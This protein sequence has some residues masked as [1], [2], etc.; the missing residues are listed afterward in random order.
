MQKNNTE[1]LKL[2]FEA[3][4]SE[5]NTLRQNIIHHS[6]MQGQSDNIALVALG[7][8]IPLILTIVNQ[9]KDSTGFILLIPVLF[10]V[11]AFTQLRQERLL[12]IAA[13]YIDANLRPQT[14]KILSL[15]SVDNARVFQWEEF[16]AQ[17]TWAPNLMLEWFSVCT[18]SI[19]GFTAGLGI[20]VVYM[21]IRNFGGPVTFYAYSY[22]TWLLIINTLIF[23]LDLVIAFRIAWIRYHYLMKYYKK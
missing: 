4:I 6:E 19:I 21:F 17:R 3:L 22:D 11:I 2:Q 8:S 1:A 23:F 7:G 12:L 14:E 10:F 15:L 16:L 13:I 18:R 5:Y 20:T 9:P